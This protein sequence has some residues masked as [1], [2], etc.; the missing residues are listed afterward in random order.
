MA[1]VTAVTTHFASA[2]VNHL[3]H[4]VKERAVLFNLLLT[5]KRKVGMGKVFNVKFLTCIPVFTS[6]HEHVCT[7]TSGLTQIVSPVVPGCLFP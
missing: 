7:C 1:Y 3:Q 4:T 5:F 2:W 6:V